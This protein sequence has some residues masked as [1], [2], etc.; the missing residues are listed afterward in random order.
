MLLSS[1]STV[2]FSCLPENFLITLLYGLLFLCSLLKY[3]S[4]LRFFPVI[5]FL[6][7]ETGGKGTGHNL[8]KNDIAVEDTT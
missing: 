3:Y 2:Y 5:I 1:T 8:E 4:T 6:R 7:S